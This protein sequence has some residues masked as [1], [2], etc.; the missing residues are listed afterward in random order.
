MAQVL[1]LLA[2]GVGI[3]SMAFS[4]VRAMVFHEHALAP[5]GFALWSV[6]IGALVH[7][8]PVF[9]NGGAVFRVT[10]SHVVWSRGPFQRAVERQSINFA[11][12]H[13]SPKLAHVG[14]LE[15]VRA[16]PTGV[17][18]RRLSIRLDGI[19]NPD[20]V[21]AIIRDAQ[22]V[23]TS[24]HG[25]LPISQRLDQGE[26]IL[27]TARPLPS[28]RSYLPI[29]SQQWYLTAIAL[30]LFAVAGFMGLRSVTML[31]RLSA[32]G[33]ET[34]GLPFLALSAGLLFGLVS[35]F[36]VALFIAH[37]VV[38]YRA[39]SL[40]DTRYLISNKRVLI[41]CGREELLL[42]R[43]HIV[44]II[45]TPAG[46]GKSNLFLVLDG[47]RARALAA[48]GAFGEFPPRTSELMPVF[49]CVQDGEGAKTALTH[50]PPSLPP[51]HWAA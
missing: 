41:Q 14:S 19:D 11:R 12:I 10:P 42:D 15:L 29:G 23:A 3:V 4:I 39:L 2:Y 1:G 18:S 24:G 32:L 50:R 44:D 36:S 9:W 7:G 33:L 31:G 51:L 28:L 48:S 8:I 21:W 38:V 27:W 43:R 13:W 46:L 16:V 22:A 25:D 40:R 35:V 17:L 49:E 47:P 20:G 34:K 45:D 37:S 5:L 30:G 26:R 6:T